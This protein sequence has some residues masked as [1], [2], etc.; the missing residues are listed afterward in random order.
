MNENVTI[1]LNKLECE[2]LMKT[3]QS[4]EVTNS[5]EYIIF[6]AKIGD[7][8]VFV[9][10]NNKDKDE[11]KV[12]FQGVGA[13]TEAEKWGTPLQKKQKK[14][15][16]LVSY[17][18]TDPQIGSDEVGFGDFFGPL[19]VVA[20]YFDNETADI[21]SKLGL[22][23]SKKLDDNYILS[24]GPLLLKKVKHKA[25][26]VHNDK[27][28][29]LVKDGYNMNKMKAMLHMNVL[30]MLKDEIKKNVPA[31]IDEFAS[32]ELFYSYLGP[33]Q[34]VIKPITF[35]QKGESYYPSIALA[36]VIARYL[37]LVEMSK[38][39]ARFKVEI[40]LGAGKKVDEFAALF[41]EKNGKAALDKI[42]K[43][44]FKNYER[45]FSS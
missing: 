24:V 45:L 37:F 5:G 31:F 1:K 11:Y 43:H 10:D 15:D 19:V 33:N 22:K 25:N 38:I 21:V 20:A 32:E 18:S 4:F 35:K 17:L 2:N 23:D 40:P 26:I 36:S 6:S 42:T 8:Q 44:N 28:N 27:F 3:Y 34:K 14:I 39:S 41:L 13:T 30:S 16:E 7:L 12:L 9:Y 29:A